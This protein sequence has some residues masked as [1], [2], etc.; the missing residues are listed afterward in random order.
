MQISSTELKKKIPHSAPPNFGISFGRILVPKFRGLHP[1]AFWCFKRC[2]SIVKKKLHSFEVLN[3][4]S[5]PL[6]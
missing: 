3:Q 1:E 5:G 2:F 6:T 4:I